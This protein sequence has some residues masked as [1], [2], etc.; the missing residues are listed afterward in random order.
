MDV[1]SE[2]KPCVVNDRFQN[3]L[4]SLSKCKIEYINEKEE[5]KKVREVNSKLEVELRETRELEKSH[6]YHLLTSREMI[7]N[8]QET[9]SQL[10]YLK[11]DVKKL[12]DEIAIKDSTIVALENEKQYIQQKHNDNIKELRATHE[13]EI[14]DVTVM[15]GRKLQQA[16]HDSDTEIA[17]F[18][19]V[20]E[21]LR[22][23]IQEIE[24]EHRDK[25]NVLVLEYEEKIQRGAAQV[26]QLQEQLA[27]QAARTD[28]NIDAYRRR[29]EELEEKLKQ[30]Q[31]KQY[32]AQSS[33]SQYESLVERPYSVERE[34]TH[35]NSSINMD[36]VL[37]TAKQPQVSLHQNKP[38]KPNT[39][40]VMY[41]GNKTPAV[42]KNEKKGHFN[43][44]K[45]RKLYSEKDLQ[46]F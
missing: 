18:T 30:S 25:M 8:L 42:Q 14:G 37:E 1:N 19:C 46:D 23:K 38:L 27:R 20:I 34:L 4:Q 45:K 12:R 9:V 13:R 43:I 32:L 21:E 17:Q 16:Q 11:R 2:E 26:S 10:V 36:P 24:A 33:Y 7:G 39:L 28:A 3:I 22:T 44:S 6:R 29:L 5:C 35:N 41:Y 15:H 40:Q 31:F